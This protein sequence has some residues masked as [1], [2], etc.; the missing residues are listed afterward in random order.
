MDNLAIEKKNGQPW[1]L[2]FQSL[3]INKLE[4]VLATFGFF[5]YMKEISYKKNKINKIQLFPEFNS[6]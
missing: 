4:N 1:Y 3:N 2:K 6:N 5:F